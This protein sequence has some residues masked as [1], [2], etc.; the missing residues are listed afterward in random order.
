MAGRRV[1]FKMLM[2]LTRRLETVEAAYWKKGFE[3]KNQ[4]TRWLKELDNATRDFS[5][6]R[7]K[8]HA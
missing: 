3:R 6:P 1:G 5:S 2:L 8:H 4:A 7:D